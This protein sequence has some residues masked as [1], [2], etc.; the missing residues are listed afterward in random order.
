MI[1]YS[2]LLLIDKNCF[3][4]V[5]DSNTLLCVRMGFYV[6]EFN[7]WNDDF[8]S[9]FLSFS[10]V[11]VLVAQV[12]LYDSETG[13]FLN[14]MHTN[15]TP[16]YNPLIYRVTNEGT[17]YYRPF[18][19]RHLVDGY[20]LTSSYTTSVSNNVKIKSFSKNVSVTSLFFFKALVF[21]LKNIQLFKIAYLNLRWNFFIL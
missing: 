7:E 16:V 11:L 14:T 3:Q 5:C 8:R 4:D 19:L 1:R 21:H 18:K 17:W 12:N 10:I 13:L 9:I 20:I 15:S 2:V 6:V